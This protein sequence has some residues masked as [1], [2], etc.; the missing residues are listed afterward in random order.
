MKWRPLYLG[1]GFGADS[2]SRSAVLSR[3]QTDR[4]EKSQSS[5]TTRIRCGAL[6]HSESGGRLRHYAMLAAALSSIVLTACIGVLALDPSLDVNQYARTS[7][8][9]RDGFTRGAIYSIAQ[10]PDGCLW[11][12][13]QFGLVRF[14]GIHAVPWQP[15]G[16]QHLPAGG[17]Y[18]LLVAQDGTLWIGAKGLASWKE[19]KLTQYSEL[20]G[21]FVLALR[22]DG[23]GTVWA[24][25]GASPPPGRL[26]SIKSG[27]VHCYGDD[28]ALGRAVVSLYEDKAGTLWAGVIGGFWRWKPGPPKFYS[29]PGDE[30]GIQVLGEDNGAL[31]VGWRNRIYRFTDGKTEPYLLPGNLGQFHARWIVRDRNAGLWIATTHGVVHV[32][33]RRTDTFSAVDGLSG[34]DVGCIF[35]DREG[36]IWVCTIDGVDRFRD[37]AVATFSAKQGLSNVLVGSVLA[38]KNGGVWMGTYGGLNRWDRGQIVIPP[39]G[40][41]KRDGELNGSLPNSL[42]EDHLGRIWV[43][44]LHELGRLENGRFSPLAG[45]PAGH[46]L[47]MAEDFEGNLWTVN[48][49]VGLVKIS[50]RDDVRQIPWSD[51]RHSDHASV[52]AADRR[53]GGLWVGFFLGGIADFSD[54]QV[55]ASYTTADG[56]GAGRVSDFY[57]DGEGVLWISTEGGLSRLKNNRVATLNSKNG[58]PCDTV[59]WAIEDNDRAFWLYTACGLIRIAHSE[60]DAWLTAPHRQENTASKIQFTVFDSSDGVRSLAS[61]GHYHPQVAKTPD[62]KLWFLPWDGV[63]VIDPRHFPFNKLPPPVRIEQITADGKTYDPAN[64]LQLPPHVRDLAIDYTALSLVAPEKIH[65]RYKL[66]GQDPDWRDVINDRQVQYSNLAPRHYTFRVMACNNSGVWNETGASLEFSVLP[67]YYQTTWFRVSCGAVFLVLLWG[68]YRLRVQQLQHQFAIG[69]EARVN[70]RT[71]IARELHDTLLQ[72]L[73]GLM[74]HFQTGIDLLPERPVEARKTLEIAVDRADQAINEGRDAVQGLRASAVETNDLVS[75]VRILGK[76]LGAADTNP[77]SAVFEVEVE[78][79][80]RNLHPILRDEVYRIAAEALRNAFRHAHAQRIEVE[81]LYGERWLRLR[82]RDDGKGIDPKLLGG[83]GRAGHFGLH[84]MRERAQLAGGKLVVWSKPDSG[85]E[86]ELSI[87]AITAYATSYRRRSWLYEKFSAKWVNDK[88]TDAKETKIKS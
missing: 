51:L 17:I 8:K 77:N 35:E 88:E 55:R 80:P 31:L 47:S 9:V 10:T 65:F 60:L 71:R 12:G 66:E 14:D 25:S 24:A 39:T 52:L 5:N 58:L 33:E 61:P 38:D 15:P 62:G 74:L 72:S 3:H 32:H 83:D 53:Q 41:P 87:P 44:T 18:S 30:S 11:L 7:W 28:G 37:S 21:Q 46:V 23:E 20:A 50:P 54:G 78:G 68:I 75:A 85:T 81:I 34:D 2:S 6:G 86:V 84:G 43:S 22:E 45:F 79:A 13:T 73:Q 1:I 76:E 4:P 69:L 27:D 42:F 19:G 82:V 57:F 63:S 56:L 16:N 36:D 59:H 26:C 49:D 70:E 40:G 64:G 48:E 67:A 29:L